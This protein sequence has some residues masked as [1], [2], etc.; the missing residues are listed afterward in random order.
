MK[1]YDVFDTI[2]A[3]G[4]KDGADVHERYAVIADGGATGFG[5]DAST[6]T[7]TTSRGGPQL[8][9]AARPAGRRSRRR[10]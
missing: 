9:R 10:L 5:E 1:V 8:L 3:P 7:G 6:A 2:P 4:G